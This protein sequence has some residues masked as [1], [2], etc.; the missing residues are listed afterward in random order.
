MKKK[1]KKKKYFFI[2][3]LLNFPFFSTRDIK[4]KKENA[5]CLF[6]CA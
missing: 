3:N 4:K 1:K 6:V 5:T 2:I